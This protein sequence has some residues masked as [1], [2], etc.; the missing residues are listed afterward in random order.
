MVVLPHV[1]KAEVTPMAAFSRELGQDQNDQ[2]GSPSSRAHLQ[3]GSSLDTVAA[4]LEER[5][6]KLPVLLR[7]G[8]KVPERDF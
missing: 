3:V 4:G 8:L 5:V 7:P 2:D 6:R 1:L